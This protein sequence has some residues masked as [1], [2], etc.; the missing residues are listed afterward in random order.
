MGETMQRLTV[1]LSAESPMLMHSDRLS[2]PLA[3]ATMEHKKLT[4]DRTLK[5]T[6]EGQRMIAKSEYL[7]SFYFDNEGNI[8]L[9]GLNIR[10]SLIEGARFFKGGK[11]VER[12]VVFADEFYPLNYDG[13]KSPEKLRETPQF[14]DSRSVVVSRSPLIRY[15]P[16]F[17]AWSTE[18]SV[19][20]ADD[21]I[22]RANL[23]R[24]W[25]QAGAFVGLGDF[26]P[27]FGRYSVEVV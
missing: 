19:I 10:K 26:R 27:L 8:A 23:L 16:V 25:E 17:H 21:I 13:P 9:P 7:N 18:V 3:E 24:Y 1:K 2:D 14:V 6:E 22:D 4:S 12:G 20:F 11:E 15:R 5:K